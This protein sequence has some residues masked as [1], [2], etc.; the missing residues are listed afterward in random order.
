VALVS[1]DCNVGDKGVKNFDFD[2]VGIG[3]LIWL[4]KLETFKT[5]P[6]VCI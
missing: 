1:G 5:V 2:R 3:A 4:L 6:C